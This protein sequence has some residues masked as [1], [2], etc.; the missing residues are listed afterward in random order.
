M[1][2]RE[3]RQA[4]DM[5]QVSVA[6]AAGITEAHYSYIENGKKRPSIA[7]AQR[8]GKVLGIPWTDFFPEAANNE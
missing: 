4:K 1:N 8:L 3:A 7:V 2:A 6:R 5:K